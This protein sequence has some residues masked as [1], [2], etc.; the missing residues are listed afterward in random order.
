MILN[1]REYAKV[2]EFESDIAANFRLARSQHDAIALISCAF[3]NE[4][5]SCHVRSLVIL[6]NVSHKPAPERVCQKD[7][8]DGSPIAH[9]NRSADASAYERSLCASARYDARVAGERLATGTA[10]SYKEVA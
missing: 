9:R 3:S 10:G 8:K 1:A 6:N 2:R 4:I 5:D 7:S